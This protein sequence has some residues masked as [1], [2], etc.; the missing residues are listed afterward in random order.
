MIAR[1]VCSAF[2]ENSQG[3]GLFAFMMAR[4]TSGRVHWNGA[5]AS[6]CGL[7]AKKVVALPPDGSI[8]NQRR[9]AT[10]SDRDVHWRCPHPSHFP[11][12]WAS[13]DHSRICRHCHRLWYAGGLP[14]DN[15]E[16]LGRRLESWTSMPEIAKALG[17]APEEDTPER[18]SNTEQ[19]HPQ[20]GA[21]L[22]RPDMQT[23]PICF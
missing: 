13:D 17:R 16:N 3:L 7:W 19:I 21:L 12:Q 18:S 5:L 23:Q 8:T 22:K 15:L 4:A 9:K 6:V 10:N 20:G 2:V 1:W 14:R 11:P